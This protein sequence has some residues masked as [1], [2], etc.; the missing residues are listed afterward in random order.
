MSKHAG[1]NLLA[2]FHNDWINYSYAYQI[3]WSGLNTLEKPV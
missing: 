3:A 1:I 2:K